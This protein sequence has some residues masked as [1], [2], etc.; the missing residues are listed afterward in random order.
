VR[1]KSV[2]LSQNKLIAI[3][4]SS[5]LAI[6][7]STLFL[8]GSNFFVLLGNYIV[9]ALFIVFSGFYFSK[10]IFNIREVLSNLIIG[11]SLIISFIIPFHALLSYF[12]FS[13][14]LYILLLI[15][16]ILLYIEKRN[17]KPFN[18]NIKTLLIFFFTYLFLSIFLIRQSL[19]V[20]IINLDQY[21]VWPD[22]YNAIAQTA[23]ITNH[24]PNI[25]PFVASANVPLDYHWGSFSLGSFIS[26]MGNFSIVTSLFRSEFIFVGLL[27]FSLLFI[28]GKSIGK[29]SLAGIFSVF[30]GGLTLF[31][32][33]PE[34]NGQ[35]G[36]SR[37][38]ISSSSMPQLV[39]NALLIF[40]IYLI[41]NFNLI[42]NKK[43]FILILFFATLSTTLSKGPNGVLILII[44]FALLILLRNL[45]TLKFIVAPTLA[46][47]LIAYFVISSPNT[48]SGQSG[49][50]LWFNPKNTMDLLI[51]GNNLT[52]SIKI[53]G[54]FILLIVISFIPFIFSILNLQKKEPKLNSIGTKCLRRNIRLFL[55]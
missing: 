24:G 15:P 37:P 50:S 20:P 5:L 6:L 51:Q 4:L 53:I 29:S 19:Y 9:I 18:F 34:F 32:T 54:F 42:K 22:T 12:K 16:I 31:P 46:G 7:A 52:S 43:L 40:C 13:F 38:L 17:I 2:N 23:E 8:D 26:F 44:T 47:F 14:V 33:F 25:Y 1:L 41:Y 48:T 10:K 21:L 49:M 28:T 39:S 45:T 36:L 11:S 3:F 55:A 27:T 30:L 35:I